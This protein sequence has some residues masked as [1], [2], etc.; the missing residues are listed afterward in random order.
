M[1]REDRTLILEC[2]ACG[3]RRPITIR[4][5]IR[6]DQPNTLREGDIVELLISDVGKKGDGIGKLYDYIVV[7]P[8]TIKG[9]KINA[10]ISKISAKTA[11]AVITTE[12]CTR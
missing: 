1:I 8:G 11:F 12:M 6:T 4:K 10:K 2:E 3:A 9:S 5:P 7:V